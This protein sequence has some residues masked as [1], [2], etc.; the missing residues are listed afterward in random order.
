MPPGSKKSSASSNSSNSTGTVRNTSAV[1]VE[2]AATTPT[3]EIMTSTPLTVASPSTC[4]SA[5]GAPSAKRRRVRGPT[6]GKRIRRIIAENKEERIP[7]YVMPEMRAFC[8]INA[9]KVEMMVATRDKAALSG[10]PLS[11]EEISIKCLGESK[12]KNYIRGFGNGPKPST[13]LSK[14]NSR[15]ARQDQLQ[16]LQRELDLIREEQR[17]ER[18]E[19]K[20]R[21]EEE[22][23]QREE[24]QRQREDKYEEEKRRWEETR[25]R[26]DE[27]WAILLKEME[28][29]KSFM[30]QMQNGGR[31]NMGAG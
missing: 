20:T 1:R 21:R 9:N 3:T 27:E 28:V 10:T 12:T 4:A 31:G 14:S 19:E 13:Y 11:T 22:Q 8:G 23:K 30:S 25:R 15:S 18:E 29:F 6:R 24:E 17:R 5:S 16:K 26:Q 7:A 2:T